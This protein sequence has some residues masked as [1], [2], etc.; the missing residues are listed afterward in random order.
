MEIK[1]T[2]SVAQY[3]EFDAEFFNGCAMCML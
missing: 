3:K 1:F 2:D